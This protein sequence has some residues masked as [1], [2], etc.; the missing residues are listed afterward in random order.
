[1]QALLAVFRVYC[2][3]GQKEMARE[4]QLKKMVVNDENKLFTFRITGDQ[5]LLDNKKTR[6]KG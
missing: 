2:K 3:L 6:A 5:A 1:M 4:E